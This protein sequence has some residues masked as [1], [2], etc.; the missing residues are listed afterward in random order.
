M[1]TN[2]SPLQKYRRQPKLYIDLPSKG[3]WYKKGALEK[4]EELEVYS[5]TANDEILTKTPD[6]L[7][8]GNATVS[9]IQNCIPSIKD[10]WSVTNRDL[11]Y[12][13]TAI[14]IASYGDSLTISHKCS[15]C[16]NEDSFALPLQRLLDHLG[17]VAPIYELKVKDFI[18]RLRPINYREVVD[19]QVTSTQVRRAAYEVTDTIK[20]AEERT[21]VLNNLYEQINEQTKNL[22]CSICTEIITPE[23]DSEQN[24]VFIKDFILNSEGDFFDAIQKLYTENNK[25]M[26]VPETEIEC[27]ECN[28]KDK[29]KPNLDY[30]NFF[31]RV[32]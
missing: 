17:S 25:K 11:D 28:H 26:I 10:A 21:K 30:S 31:S 32:S 1:E 20:D 16:E 2:Q 12:I 27:S 22:I 18:F 9:I 7:L 24:P 15:K 29:V 3:Q 19:N 8:N 6:A 14:R 13:L 23:G 5:M 4:T